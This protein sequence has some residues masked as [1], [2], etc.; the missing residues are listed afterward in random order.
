[1]DPLG[2]PTVRTVYNASGQIVAQCD[3][4]GN[5][6]TLAG[7]ATF[8][9]NSAANLQT[10]VNA[11]GFRTDLLLDANGN[12]LTERHWLDSVN[13]LDTVRTYDSNNNLLTQTDPAG[14]ITTNTYDGA[15]NLLSTTDPLGHVTQHTY[16][17]CN[18]VLTTTDPA[19]NVSTNTYDPACNLLTVTD[20]L[21]HVTTY[22]YNSA[23][24]QSDM[25]D[26]VGNHWVWAY[27]S[28]GYLSSL[29]DPFGNA[30]TYTN[31][32]AGD[33]LTRIDRNGREIDFA[34]DTAHHP[35]QETWNTTPP[36]V[37]NY[38]YNSAGQLTSA[39]DP[40]SALAIT[41][42]NTGLL[43]TVDNNGTPSV[44]RVV[45]TYAYDADSNVTSVQDSLGGVT[46]Y[47]YDALDRLSQANQSGTGVNPKLV[48]F[49]YDNASFLTQI[50]RF[51]DLA[52]AQPVANTFF[53]TDC[54]GCP[55]RITAIRHRRALDNSVIDDLTFV[56]DALGNIVSSSDADGAH[57]YG[58][59][60]AQR[61]L[62]ATH[63]QPAFQP[64]EFYQY[65]AVG[66]RV[67]SHISN[68][69]LYSYMTTG[70]GTRLMQDQQFTYQYDKEG[71]LVSQSDRMS[72][73][74]T[75]YNYD[76]RNRITTI[77]FMTAGALAGSF[78]Y[79]YDA[80]D[81]RILTQQGSQTTAAVYDFLNQ[82][83]E[84]TPNGGQLHR[85]FYSRVAD[86]LLADEV[87]GQTRWFFADQVRTNRELTTDNGTLLVHYTYDSFGR[88]LSSSSP[89]FVNHI[90]FAS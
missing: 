30:T 8:S 62:A 72:G 25:I 74:Y 37:T 45:M 15:A 16:N 48:A 36:R 64:N 85:R 9:P 13:H 12:V 83:L 51:S 32:A 17:S 76:Y 65:D 20:A 19:G 82:A 55:G 77:L 47:V 41:Y 33:L 75:V 4:N 58:Y 1:M 86:G 35:T 54:D 81:R 10:I 88:L 80:L 39:V 7:C 59:D 22:K 34:Y 18:K 2:R 89:G 71:N 14:N 26:A 63:S 46:G 44:P 68:A 73:A 42:T 66:N 79:A 87:T 6:T 24:Q 60:S 40:D 3:A 31:S 50:S 28:N 43:S 23:G 21:S 29:T 67:A 53:Q 78:Q 90:T 70:V 49:Q 69:Y 27:D 56:R 57:N 38:A 84:A 52:G 5:P 11:R 61:L